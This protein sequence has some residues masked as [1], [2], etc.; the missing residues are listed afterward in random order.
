MIKTFTPMA[1]SYKFIQ[2]DGTAESAQAI[3]EFMGAKSFNHGIDRTADKGGVDTLRWI[4]IE[5]PRI[6]R[7]LTRRTIFLYKGEVIVKPASGRDRFCK[8]YTLQE[9]RRIFRIKV[10]E[11]LENE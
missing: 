3:A 1:Q 10:G 9:A 4:W 8:N 5:P 6:N 11:P 2:Y 7:R